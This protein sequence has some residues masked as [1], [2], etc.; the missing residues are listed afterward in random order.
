MT[1]AARRRSTTAGGGSARRFAERRRQVRRERRRPAVLAA[2]LGTVVLLVVWTVFVSSLFAV[3]SVTVEGT[4]RLA[5]AEVS[6][7]TRVQPGTPLARIDVV[8]VARRVRA[9][10]AVASVTVRRHWPH[11][12]VVHVVERT[13]VA[14]VPSA[15]GVT[16]VD[17]SG[18]PF[19]TAASAP[20]GTVSLRVGGALPGP[21]DASARAAMSVWRELPGQVRRQ[22]TA[23]SAPT[24]GGVT[25]S[26]AGDRTVIWGSPGNGERKLAVLTALLRR[27]A[28]VYDV[29]A[30]DVAVTR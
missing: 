10:P 16:L 5:P 21:G 30:P 23:V 22:L 14:A 27:P 19:A 7:A 8:A 4:L 29:S 3:R 12:L 11:T 18:L 17:A 24:P 6:A 25:L 1:T 20:R 9:L 26:L 28:H 2:S 15:T 13:A